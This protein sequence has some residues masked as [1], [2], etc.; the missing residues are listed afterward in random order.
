MIYTLLCRY[1]TIF[2]PVLVMLASQEL[3]V[4]LPLTDQEVLNNI[5]VIIRRL[6]S[7]VFSKSLSTQKLNMQILMVMNYNYIIRTEEM[8]IRFIVNYCSHRITIN[9]VQFTCRKENNSY[10]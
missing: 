7:K 3:T 2:K 10:L 1:V 6:M 8:V 4:R 5:I 9:E